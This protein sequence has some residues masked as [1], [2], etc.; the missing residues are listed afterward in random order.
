MRR[1]DDF[2]VICTRMEVRRERWRAGNG[3]STD[4]DAMQ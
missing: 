4:G 1:A 2:N 3:N